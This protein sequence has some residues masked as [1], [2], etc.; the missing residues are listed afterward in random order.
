MIRNEKTRQLIIEKTASIF[1]KKGYTGTYLSDLTKATGLTKGSIY[2]NFRNKNEVAVEAF[3]YNYR[4]LTKEVVQ[5]MEQTERSDEKFLV[6]LKHY[7]KEYARIFKN[8]GCVILNTAIDSDDGNELLRSE[9]SKTL[10]NWKNK[11]KSIL[12]EGIEKGEIKETDTEKFIVRMIALIEGS[13]MMA[14]VLNQPDILL[15]NMES[16]END[17]RALRI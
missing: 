2:G 12:D 17:I 4:E 7:K 13:I 14:K 8:G 5:K 6:Y 3:K 15:N 10:L 11:F 16:L 9:V 1:N